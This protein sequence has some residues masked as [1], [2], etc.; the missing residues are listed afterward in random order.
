MAKTPTPLLG[1]NNNVRHRGRI[2]HIQTEDSG[3]KSPRIVTHLF[4]DG[5]RIVKTSRTDYAEHV[6]Q[7]DMAPVVRRLMKEQ[8]KGM[9]ISLR[10]GELDQLLEQMCGARLETPSCRP[11]RRCS[12]ER[13]VAE[14][15]SPNKLR[16]IPRATAEASAPDRADCGHAPSVRRRRR[17]CAGAR[18]H[19]SRAAPRG[20]DG[21]TAAVDRRSISRSARSRRP[22]LTRSRPPPQS[23]RQASRARPLRHRFRSGHGSLLEPRAHTGC[24]HG[25]GSHCP[26]IGEGP[27]RRTRPTAIFNQTAPE[28]QSIFGESVIS[29]QSLDEVIL[30]YLAE[31]LEVRRQVASARSATSIRRLAPGSPRGSGPRFS[32]RARRAR[33]RGS[34]ARLDPKCCA[35]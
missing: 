26:R 10:A 12:T 35:G 17:H 22:A 8:H 5:G 3:V 24:R 31:D 13:A 14:V 6:G 21:A 11:P 32:H 9:F 18:V 1:F 20:G 16:R 19:Q 25:R 29:E 2:F 33:H 7:K 34:R 15:P 28:K 23:A 30:S 27:V 4:A